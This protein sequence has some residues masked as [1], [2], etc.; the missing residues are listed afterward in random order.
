MHAYIDIID[1]PAGGGPEHIYVYVNKQSGTN[2]GKIWW[3]EEGVRCSVAYDVRTYLIP[4]Q[5]SLLVAAVVVPA[6]LASKLG[7][8]ALV[9]WRTFCWFQQVQASAA[10]PA[11]GEAAVRCCGRGVRKWR[12]RMCVIKSNILSDSE[13]Q[14][15]GIAGR[16]GQ[17]PVPGCAREL[18]R[19]PLPPAVGWWWWPAGASNRQCS[20]LLA[21]WLVLLVAS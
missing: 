14:D 12:R 11:A 1:P 16:P 8:H 10:Q 20:K 2:H 4:G 15:R 7:R 17:P 5:V 19:L 18:S 21:L 6:S 13:E 3:K 9:A